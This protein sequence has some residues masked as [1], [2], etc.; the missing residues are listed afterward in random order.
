[1]VRNDLSYFIGATKRRKRR[2]KRKRKRRGIKTK[3]QKGGAFGVGMAAGM[4]APLMMGTLG[5]ILN[6]KINR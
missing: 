3:P 2:Q 1:M 6:V 4:L 5:K